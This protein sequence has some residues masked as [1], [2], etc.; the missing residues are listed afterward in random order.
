M[1][2]RVGTVSER[3][4]IV[5][6]RFLEAEIIESDF[7]DECSLQLDCWRSLAGKAFGINF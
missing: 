2:Y 4:Q 1:Y 6:Q 7:R 5:V 3:N